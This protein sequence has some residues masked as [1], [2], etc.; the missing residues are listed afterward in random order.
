MP[1]KDKMN[2]YEMKETLK[3][4]E[5]ASISVQAYLRSFD[6]TIDVISVEDDKRFQ[7][8]D[9]DLLWVYIKDGKT[10]MKKIEVKGDRYSNTGNFFIETKS[11][12]QKDSPGCF[13]YTE[14]DYIYYY[15]M[16]SRELNVMPMERSRKW[17]IENMDRFKEV[18]LRT[19]V[20]DVGHYTSLGR[21]VP[22]HVMRREAGV[23]HRVLPKDLLADE[24]LLN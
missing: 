12:V 9:V 11:N 1:D 23:R 18:P 5:E 22:K 3:V 6:E 10:H 2:E 17:F 13:M 21:I 19:K 24:G 14:A 15:F 8:K 7:A 16:D 20:G 4:S